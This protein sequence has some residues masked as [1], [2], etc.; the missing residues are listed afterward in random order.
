MSPD[1]FD[2]QV[3]LVERMRNESLLMS[4]VSG[5]Y[6]YVPDD[7]QYPYV[8]VDQLNAV[9][10]GMISQ[11]SSLSIQQLLTALSTDDASE[12]GFRQVREIG[13]CLIALFEARPLIVTGWASGLKRQLQ[14]A[15]AAASIR[16][17]DDKLRAAL[18]TV[19][20]FGF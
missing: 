20:I 4:R 13:S 3:A 14:T 12:K 6:D 8:V 15:I 19:Q 10:D 16:R 9:R 17:V 1:L 18:V 7:A 2:I 11:S 5:V